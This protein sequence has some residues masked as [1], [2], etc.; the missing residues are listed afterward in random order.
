MEENRAYVV[1]PRNDGTLPP[2][3]PAA[4]LSR[5]ALRS[6]VASDLNSILDDY[7]LPNEGSLLAKRKRLAVS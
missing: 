2:H 5:R 4:G 1:V 3:W 6:L 7:G